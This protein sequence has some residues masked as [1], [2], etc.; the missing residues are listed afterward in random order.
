MAPLYRFADLLR[1]R[2]H[3]DVGRRGEDIA[4]RY[5]RRSG[6]IVVARN[7]RPPQGGGELDLVA[8]QRETL[9]FVEVK[10]RVSGEWNAP[11]RDVDEEKIRTL[12][13]AARDYM[14]RAGVDPD[15]AR[16]DVLA[17]TGD[18]VRHLTDAFPL[19]LSL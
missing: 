3:A 16:F 11:E 12:R 7:W 4:H 9:V 5:L 8:W 2:R 10:S 15:K 13:R 18:R 6:Y 17:I 19:K 14:R 1:Y